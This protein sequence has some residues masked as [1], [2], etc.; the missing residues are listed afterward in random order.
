MKVLLIGVNSKYIHTAL[1]VDYIYNMC[2]DFD[3]ERLE[4]NINQNLNFVYGEI[5]KRKPD[6]ILFST[7][8]WNIEF[9]KKLTS[10]LSKVTDAVIG[11][12]GIE[13]SFAVSLWSV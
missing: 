11:W 10:D 2:R 13:A 3:V 7:Y 12:G 8:I 4:F 1:A 6:V 9:I 5:I